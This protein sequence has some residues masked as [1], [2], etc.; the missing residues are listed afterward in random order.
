MHIFQA[1][2]REYAEVCSANKVV[3]S[4]EMTRAERT[5]EPKFLGA[6]GCADVCVLGKASRS[7]EMLDARHVMKIINAD[8][9]SS[10]KRYRNRTL[11][12]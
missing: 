10:P 3:R 9:R 1:M 2:S 4:L 5:G 8:V 11:F 6:A 12:A 7:L